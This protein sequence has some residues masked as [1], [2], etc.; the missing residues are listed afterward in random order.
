M[1][2]WQGLFHPARK[3]REAYWKI[4]NNLYIGGQDALIPAYPIMED[5]GFNHYR[6]SVILHA[7]CRGFVCATRRQSYMFTSN[8][9]V[10]VVALHRT[11]LSRTR[12]R[13]VNTQASARLRIQRSPGRGNLQPW[14]ASKDRQLAL[15]LESVSHLSQKLF[16]VSQEKKYDFRACPWDATAAF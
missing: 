3:V 14:F 16:L 6:R 12:I 4:Y 10:S 9:S 11:L 7:P 15:L 8:N 13:P 2:C 1:V 5:D